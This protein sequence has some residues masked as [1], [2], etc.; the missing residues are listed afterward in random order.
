MDNFLHLYSSLLYALAGH[1]HSQHSSSR[2]HGYMKA[3]AFGRLA[4]YKD[5]MLLLFSPCFDCV[6]MNKN[7]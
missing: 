6:L 7:I 3:L 5:C 4:S 2:D 1:M